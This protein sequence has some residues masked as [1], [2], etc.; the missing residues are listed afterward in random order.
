MHIELGDHDWF[1]FYRKF[2]DLAVHDVPGKQLINTAMTENLVGGSPKL[3]QL[4]IQMLW[5]EF[6]E[7]KA[8]G[9]SLQADI[10]LHCCSLALAYLKAFGADHPSTRMLFDWC[11]GLD[12]ELDIFLRERGLMP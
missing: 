10:R 6:K 11:R 3:A 8:K 4:T 1:E 5:G 12:Q 7:L 2:V 9:D